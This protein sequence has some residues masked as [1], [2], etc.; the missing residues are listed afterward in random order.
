MHMQIRDIF[1]LKKRCHQWLNDFAVDY[2]SFND[3]VLRVI[4]AYR[5]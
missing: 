2:L 4:G 5:Q 1:A 3:E